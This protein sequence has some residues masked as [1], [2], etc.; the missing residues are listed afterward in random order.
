M[1]TESTSKPDKAEINKKR[2]LLVLNEVFGVELALKSLLK[3][4]A[5]QVNY[6]PQAIVAVNN[7]SGVP[8]KKSSKN[9]RNVKEEIENF[10]DELTL[11]EIKMILE[12]EPAKTVDIDTFIEVIKESKDFDE[13]NKKIN[14]ITPPDT[15]ITI[16][17]NTM[18][19]EKI[20]EKKFL[21]HLG[22]VIELRNDASHLKPLS[23]KNIKEAKKLRGDLLAMIKP[24][25]SDETKIVL[26]QMQLDSLERAIKTI[27]SSLDQ[28]K[29]S[30][31]SKATSEINSDYFKII[32]QKFR[33]N[34]LDI[35]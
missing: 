17:G 5:R 20:N 16:L 28:A 4:F 1:E 22:R 9:V 23:L 33:D 27:F 3:N 25:V 14:D 7:K 19:A 13:A 2:S 21:R 24:R 29:N 35:F 15:L 6:V 18:L 31:I 8:H 12:I 11:N 10:I 32:S 26:S 30:T 34:W